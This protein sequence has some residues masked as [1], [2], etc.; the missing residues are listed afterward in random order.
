MRYL[1]R[2]ALVIVINV[3]AIA[4]PLSAQTPRT[5]SQQGLLTDP[6][7]DPVP[8]ASRTMTFKIYNT[9]SG[10][11]ALW[12]ESKSVATVNGVFNTILGSDTPISGLDFD[13]DLWLGITVATDGEMPRTKLTG[14]PYALGLV[15]P[16]E[17]SIRIQTADLAGDG[18]ERMNEDLTIYANDAMVGLYSNEGGGAGSGI[19]FGEM[20][21][22]ALTD[23]WSLYRRTSGAGSTFRLSYGS[24]SNYASNPTVV[25][26]DTTGDI[27]AGDLHYRDPGVPRY[28]SVPAL[29]FRP[30][31][32]FP[33]AE[34][35]ALH[36]QAWIDAGATQLVAPIN[37]PKN[38]VLDS[39]YCWIT[40]T[41]PDQNLGCSLGESVAQS[42]GSVTSGGTASFYSTGTPGAEKIGDSLIHLPVDNSRR[43]FY[44][45]VNADGAGWPT[46][47]SNLK[48]NMAVVKYHALEPL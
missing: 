17:D 38:A 20:V 1:R 19:Q 15:T 24:N 39:L 4:A 6:S 26:I 42:D 8:D 32:D 44:I 40:D 23:K 37:L 35:T 13:Q 12:T 2:S 31:G 3:I 11:S 41:D 21:S 28:L 14:V 43:A 5:I 46:A 30:D 16:Y 34:Y 10:G 27:V 45:R 9:D 47:G 7:G 25:E 48:L 33:A 29:A 18:T 36:F 22:G